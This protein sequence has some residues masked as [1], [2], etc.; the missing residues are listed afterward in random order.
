M[1]EDELIIK[2]GEIS[3]KIYT[4]GRLINLR[5]L[6]DISLEL[7]ELADCVRGNGWNTQ[8]PTEKGLYVVLTSQESNGV[9]ASVGTYVL[10]YWDGYSFKYL[11]RRAN[12][13]TLLNEKEYSWIKWKK[14]NE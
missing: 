10:D 12:E 6:Y 7:N 5:E 4:I 14:V 2:I 8:D 1:T 9:N 13:S 11:K 3:M